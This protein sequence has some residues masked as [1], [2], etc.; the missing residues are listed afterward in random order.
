[1]AETRLRPIRVAATFPQPPEAVW[2]VLA[3][4]RRDSEWCHLVPSVTQTH[5]DGPGA[6][7][8]YAFKQEL[9]GGKVV[10]GTI[11]VATFEPP[12]TIAWNVED[13]VRKYH[14]T[15][16]LGVTRNG[17]TRVT[18]VSHPTFKR[19]LGWK[20]ILIPLMTKKALKQQFRA[21]S[22][23]VAKETQ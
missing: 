17:G 12:C 13:A 11:E 8:T 4:S 15:M 21:L 16:H 9:L 7:A 20:K 2:A 1:M 3:D 10:D 14:I 6:D 22:H 18:Q 23:I 19:A 5:G